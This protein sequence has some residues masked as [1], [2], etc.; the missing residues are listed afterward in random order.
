[1]LSSR[2]LT[3]ASGPLSDKFFLQLKPLVTPLVCWLHEYLSKQSMFFSFSGA[4]SLQISNFVYCI[5]SYRML[6]EN[7]FT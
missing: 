2:S 7:I 1:M 5:D 6:S 4:W 3:E